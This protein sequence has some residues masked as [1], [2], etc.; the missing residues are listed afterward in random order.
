MCLFL[1]ARMEEEENAKLCHVKRPEYC[2]FYSSFKL[3]E[4]FQEQTKRSTGNRRPWTATVDSFGRCGG[5]DGLGNSEA[6]SG[7][8]TL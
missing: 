1:V 7:I 5:H 3:K 8:I 2:V 6:E 4:E